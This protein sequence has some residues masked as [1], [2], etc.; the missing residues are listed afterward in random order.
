[1]IAG[2][3]DSLTAKLKPISKKQFK[4]GYVELGVAPYGGS[5]NSTWWDRDLGVGG[6]VIIKNPDGKIES[7]LVNLDWPIARVSTLAP[8]FGAPAN[9]P[10]NKETQMIPIIGLERL[11]QLYLNYLWHSQIYSSEDDPQLMPVGTFAAGQPARLVKA[12]SSQ[13]GIRDG[14]SKHTL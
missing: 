7:R 4:Q 11:T 1:M 2:H 10:F 8:H 9:G 14:T 3:V 6:R 5:L 13:L 12:V